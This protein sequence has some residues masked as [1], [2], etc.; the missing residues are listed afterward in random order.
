MSIP[1]LKPNSRKFSF[2][3]QRLTAVFF[4][5]AVGLFLLFTLPTPVQAAEIAVSGSCTLDLAI[6][7]ANTNT[8]N[9]GCPAGDAGVDTIVLTEDVLLASPLTNI[10]S[11]IIISG[12][13]YTIQRSSASTFRIFLVNGG[14][15]T[16]N[17]A[18]LTN[19]NASGGGAGGALYV[20]GGGTA[21]LN[22][23]TVTN[24]IASGSGGAIFLFGTGNSL[25]LNHS[26]VVDNSATDNGGGLWVSGS[27]SRVTIESST[28]MSNT[29][30]AS[31]GGAWLGDTTADINRSTIAANTANGG[32]G[33]GLRSVGTVTLT[34]STISGNRAMAAGALGGG[35]FNG[36][37][38]TINNSTITLNGS[39]GGYPG[40]GGGIGSQGTG[41][42]TML[43]RSIVSGNE[44]ASS[45]SEISSYS[46]TFNLGN[47]NLFGVSWQTTITTAIY[48]SPASDAPATLGDSRTAIQ[49]SPY[50]AAL[51]QILD[52]T[53]TD[54]GGGTLTHAL[55]NDLGSPTV[56]NPA[57]DIDPS[58]N[59][60][61]GLVNNIDQRGIARPQDGLQDG[62][63]A[64][65]AGAVEYMPLVC[66]IRQDLIDATPNPVSY[67]FGEVIITVTDVGTDFDCLRVEQINENHPNAS[68]AI[69]TDH[70]WR[71]E[72]YHWNWYNGAEVTN[73][74]NVDLTLPY[75]A[76]DETTRACRWVN[77]PGA[78]WDCG[79]LNPLSPI[80][81]TTYIS[82]TS[83]TR[84]GISSFSEWAVGQNVN[85]TAVS[86]HTL[87]L[88]TPTQTSP[89]IIWLTAVL[90]LTTLAWFWPR[91]KPEA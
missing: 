48:F 44:S 85:P 38:M 50:E 30:G 26:T 59:C 17:D 39:L 91:R 86:L 31:G 40:G 14:H 67:T 54:N 33:G 43:N 69:Q 15:L 13:G 20:E 51:Y 11:T 74:F 21:V 52:E 73:D 45:G 72:A 55:V 23:V 84:H 46:T 34:N 3:S 81:T 4:S 78:G 27:G 25:T 6:R 79:P 12:N 77:G 60:A 2:Y 36:A 7:A 65:D 19:G 83:V 70:F 76:A 56:T 90:T 42:V 8:A 53:L 57:I 62:T 75:N 49:G 9:A 24:N 5:T 64:C 28:I 68:T 89:L 41:A 87:S 82:G 58:A 71:I 66:D 29:A 88:N 47:H 16:V 18:T 22:S 37:T 10:T 1:S 80:T 61:S 63:T 32:N 35:L